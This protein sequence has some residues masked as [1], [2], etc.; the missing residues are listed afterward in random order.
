LG[1]Q[2]IPPSTADVRT[3]WGRGSIWVSQ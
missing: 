3:D 2:D 1:L